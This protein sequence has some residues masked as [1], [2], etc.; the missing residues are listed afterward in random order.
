MCQ[1]NSWYEILYTLI[2]PKF[3][4]F[5]LYKSSCV[6]QCSVPLNSLGPLFYFHKGIQSKVPIIT[7]E[8]S[9]HKSFSPGM[10]TVHVAIRGPTGTS[11][12]LLLDTRPEPP[13]PQV[14]IRG[15]V[16][17]LSWSR[18]LCFSYPS[19]SSFNSPSLTL[20]PH[21]HTGT[22][23][24]ESGSLKHSKEFRLLRR[25]NTFKVGLFQLNR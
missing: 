2:D 21:R 8:G 24:D 22:Y 20:P 19:L 1:R 6:I 13:T 16:E 7:R 10:T 3:W 11:W 4:N 14:Y 23:E 5:Y 12:Q 15:S 17:D 25:V 9:I 18:P